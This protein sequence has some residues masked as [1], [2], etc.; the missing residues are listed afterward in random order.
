MNKNSFTAKYNI[1]KI[2]YYEIYGEIYC[3]IQRE[4]EIKGWKRNKKMQLIRE[5]NPKWEDLLQDIY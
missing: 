1:N 3:A 4:K 2:V 5:F